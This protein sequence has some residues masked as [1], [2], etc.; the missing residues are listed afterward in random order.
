MP[1][2]AIGGVEFHYRQAGDGPVGVLYVHG[3]CQSSL[4]WEPALHQ[5]PAGY[6]A[7]A[8]DLKGFGGSSKPAGTYGIAVAADEV[9]AFLDALGL[10]QVVLVGNSM[11]GVV[12]QCFAGLYGSRLRRLVLVGTGP[13]LRDPAGAFERARR[14]RTMEWTRETL[15]DVIRPFFLTPPADFPQLVDEALRAGREALVHLTLSMGSLNVLPGLRAL[16]VPTLIVQGAQDTIRPPEEGQ[17]IQ[18]MIPGS[19][20]HVLEG[21]SHT[22][23]L[24]QAEAFH[25]LLWRF[26][27]AEGASGH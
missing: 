12:A 9:R 6:R 7:F 16:P 5:L 17:R 10:P 22:P 21:A 24:E 15:A 8:L 13:Y 23:M 18:A 19:Q 11:G 1:T 2:I 3:F 27:A 25:A 26:L 4:W 14:F 20:L